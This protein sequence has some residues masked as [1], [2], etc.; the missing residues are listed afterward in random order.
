M[1]IL[2]DQAVFPD[3][4]A[5][6]FALGKEVPAL[7]MGVQVEGHKAEAPVNIWHWQSDRQF[8]AS[9]SG[10]PDATAEILP[11]RR[12]WELFL[13]PPEA[14]A[15]APLIASTSTNLP[16]LPS[17]MTARDAGSLQSQVELKPH[18]VLESNAEGFGTLTPQ[19]APSQT[20]WGAAAWSNGVWRVLMVRDLR[21]NDNLDVPLTVKGKIPVSF[22]VWDGSKQDRNGTKLISGWHWFDLSH[23]P[24]D[25]PSQAQA[26]T[27]QKGRQP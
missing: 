1:N 11:P 18:A 21:S 13:L 5:V 24:S 26:Q 16:S 7:P 10:K 19:P 9:L 2:R 23:N 25:N 27:T 14:R 6:M 17:F 20:V 15:A 4:V 8:A 12:G 3:G 22:A